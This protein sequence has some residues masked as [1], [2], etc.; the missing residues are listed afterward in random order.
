MNINHL[1]RKNIQALTPYQSA[2]RLGGKGDIWLNANEYPTSPNF[3]L[4]NRTFN[5]Y[6][7]PQPQAVVEGYAAYAGVSP[8]NVLVSRGGDESIELII[9]AFCEADDNV[10]YCPPTYGMYAVSAET[11]GI[12]CKTVPL[13]ADFQLNL[14]EIERQLDGVKVV[15]VC[16]PN[17]PTGNLIKRSDLLALLQMTAGRAIVVVDEAYIEFC[18]EATMATELANYPHLAIIRTL[19]KAFALAGLRCGFTLANAE[20]IHV[21]QKVIAPYPL[22]V[23][24]SDIAAQALQPQGLTQMQRSVAELLANRA[25]LQKKLENL[26]LVEQV[27]P[28]EANYL[29][30][31]FKDGQKVFRSLWEQGIILRDQHKALNLKDCVR[32]TVGTKEEND[33]VLEAIEAIK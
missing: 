25:D 22:P 10:L 12:A 32:I 9:R 17:N 14:V 31:K 15:F 29:L 5:R 33:K 3:D 1:S 8:N 4:T 7:E 28:S 2:R 27:Y 20:L 11:C 18:P 6:P 23:P 21:L 13:M 30:V 24:V 19:S 16:S 26:P